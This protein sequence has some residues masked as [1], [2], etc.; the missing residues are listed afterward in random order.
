M[1]S[2]VVT[3]A[4]DTCKDTRPSSSTLQMQHIAQNRACTAFLRGQHGCSPLQL[5]PAAAGEGQP[6]CLPRARPSQVPFLPRLA[7]CP[8]ELRAM[9]QTWSNP[10]AT[11]PAHS[12]ATRLPAQSAPHPGAICSDAS[13]DVSRWE[14]NNQQTTRSAT[15]QPHQDSRG[16]GWRQKQRWRGCWGNQFPRRRYRWRYGWQGAS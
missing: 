10:K 12:P 7:T 2:C 16:R 11:R 9:L 15:Y 13:S 14:H 3:S 4:A 5:A 1:L 6:A 8:Q